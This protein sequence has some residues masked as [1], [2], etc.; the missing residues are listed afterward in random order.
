MKR[1]H[2][3]K[4]LT[5]VQALKKENKALRD[6]NKSLKRQVRQ[7]QKTEHLLEA[8]DYEDPQLNFE[9]VIPKCPDCNKGNLKEYNVVGRHWLECEFCDYDT[10]KIKK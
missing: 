1:Q 7:L 4:E 6:E 5:E 8:T 3:K 9:Q 10:R 2:R